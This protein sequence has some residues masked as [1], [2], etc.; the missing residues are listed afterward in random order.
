MEKDTY[1]KEQGTKTRERR[2]GKI[3]KITV[4]VAL[5]GLKSEWKGEKQEKQDCFLWNLIDI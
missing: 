3:Q 5:C 1:D 4:T 2:K